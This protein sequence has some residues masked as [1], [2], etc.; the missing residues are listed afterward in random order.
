MGDSGVLAAWLADRSFY[1]VLIL[2]LLVVGL[3]LAL[4]RR[5]RSRPGAAPKPSH[6]RPPRGSKRTRT[7]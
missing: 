6:R 1:A 3:L 7:P 4:V 5:H 2:A